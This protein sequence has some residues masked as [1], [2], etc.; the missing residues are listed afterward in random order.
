VSQMSEMLSHNKMFVQNKEY[1]EFRTGK[2][3]EKRMVIVTCMDTRLVELLPKALNLRNGDAKIIKSAGA[4]VSHPFGGI[5]RSIL[6]AVYELNANEVFI[7]GHHDCGM[8]GLNSVSILEKA[9]ERGIPANVI[10]TLDHAG[11]DL[12]GWLTGFDNVRDA[13]FKSVNN[14]RN[15]PL[16]P[17]D[18]LVHGLI[19]HPETGQLDVVVDGNQQLNTVNH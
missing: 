14:V 17:K 19:I 9:S 12:T 2:F 3:P 13:V 5:M 10:Q 4:V 7:I 1:E 18:I 15:H 11:I 16:V 6:V 8:T